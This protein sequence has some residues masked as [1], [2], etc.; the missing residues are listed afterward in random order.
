MRA[1]RAS[2]ALISTL[3]LSGCLLPQPDTPI[4]PPVRPETGRGSLPVGAPA[5]APRPEPVMA[6]DTAVERTTSP[7]EPNTGMLAPTAPGD[8]TAAS[9]KA[10]AAFGQLEGKLEGLEAA[11]VTAVP[12]AGG[13]PLIAEVTP[14]GTFA[15]SLAPG[16]YWLDFTV[17]GSEQSVRLALPQLV[18]SLKTRKLTIAITAEPRE[19]TIKEEVELV[20]TPAATGL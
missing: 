6:P 12:V 1:I 5:Q 15:L 16:E 8:A 11:R 7:A 19:A 3:A 17:A 13:P 20:E 4:I 9:P 10:S 2:L 14:S 18:V